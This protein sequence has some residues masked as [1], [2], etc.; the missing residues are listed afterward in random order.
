METKK[1]SYILNGTLYFIVL[2]DED[3][4]RFRRKYGIVLQSA[5]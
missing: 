1:Y 3:A 5:D 2:N 4:E